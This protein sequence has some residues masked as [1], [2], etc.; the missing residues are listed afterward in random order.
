MLVEHQH[1]RQ[2]FNLVPKK[3]ERERSR[4]KRRVHEYAFAE[5]NIKWHGLGL[6]EGVRGW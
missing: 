5:R 1:S 3:L 4:L 2:Q 6:T